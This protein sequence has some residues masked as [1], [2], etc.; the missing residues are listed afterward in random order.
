MTSP[1]LKAL[2]AE[3]IYVLRETAAEFARPVIL[4]SVGKDSSVLLHLAR[5]A[6]FPG[7][8]P[9]PVLH[10]DTKWKFREMITH[11]DAIAKRYGL[12]LR[13]HTNEDAATA[14]VTPFTHSSVVYNDLMKTEG[15]RQALRRWSFD[16]A[17]GGAR[18][19]EEKSRAKER[20]FSVRSAAQRWD[21]KAQRPELWRLFNTRLGDGESMRV[22]PLSN[23]TERD[24]WHYIYQEDIPLV[25]L[26]FAKPRPVVRRKGAWIMVDDDRM[27]LEPGE[28]P[29]MKWVRFRSIGCYPYTGAIESTAETL[30]EILM[31]MHATRTSEREGRLIDTDQVGSMEKK[32]Q[33]GYF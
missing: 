4:Y 16:A 12:D 9:M 32:K 21:P 10:V 1:H 2:E 11:R 26:Y 28:T 23:W 33:A 18:R 3:A 19:D 22:F 14:G 5:K 30:P 17:I 6:F 27:P 8:I 15:L 7:P 31:E 20:F 24:I 13:I 29:E 25:P